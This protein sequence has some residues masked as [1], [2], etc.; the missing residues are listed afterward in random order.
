ME[1][2]DERGEGAGNGAEAADTEVVEGVQ[3]WLVRRV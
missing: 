2:V 1:W 3:A